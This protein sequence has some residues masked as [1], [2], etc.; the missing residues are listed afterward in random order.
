MRL[1][2]ENEPVNAMYYGD[3]GTGKTTALAAMA[4][5]GPIVYVNAEAGLKARPLKQ[6]GIDI[7][8][9]E[10]WP[11]PGE[12]LTFD[13]LEKLHQ[14]IL[15]D[16]K[17]DPEAWVGVVWD[18][19]TEIHQAVLL[20]VREDAVAKGERQGKSIDPF[21]ND[22]SYYGTMTEKMRLMVRRFRDLPCHF[23]VS[24]LERRDQDDDG[25]V[26]YGPAATPALANDLF[27]YVDVVLHTQTD[28]VAGVEEFQGITRPHGKYRAKDRLR[29]LPRM[30]ID[31]RFDRL[32]AYANGDLVAADDPIMT[33]AQ[34]RRRALREEE[35][36][37]GKK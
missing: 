17:S 20:E 19:V 35:E 4:N 31:P 6:L 23:G 28:V 32:V 25:T 13:G 14:R 2:E 16:L 15:S 30:F 3:G 10:V 11:D 21:F 37:K 27:G 36:E 7:G 34:D 8:N 12:T 18:S 33:E 29:A 9:I 24:A 1:S 26:K 5:L 22:L